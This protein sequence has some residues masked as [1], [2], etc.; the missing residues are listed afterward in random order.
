ML[1]ARHYKMVKKL[2]NGYPSTGKSDFILQWSNLMN[3]NDL[4]F[5]NPS[6]LKRFMKRN[7]LKLYNSIIH[8]GEKLSQTIELNNAIQ[9]RP[10]D[11]F[12]KCFKTYL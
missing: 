11:V 2:L 1:V 12:T 8:Y 6:K 4:H 7:S 9:Y 5:L 10:K 3:L